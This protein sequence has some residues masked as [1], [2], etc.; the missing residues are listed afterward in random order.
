MSV[1][2]IVFLA[3]DHATGQDLTPEYSLLEKATKQGAAKFAMTIFAA[4][5]MS[6]D[7]RT[8]IA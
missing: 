8:N 1:T 2:Q 5:E 4:I 3:K 7:V 6:T